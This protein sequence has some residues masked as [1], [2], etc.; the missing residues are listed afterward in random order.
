[1][2]RLLC[3]GKQL[4]QKCNDL[5]GERACP[6]VV[7]A[8]RLLRAKVEKSRGVYSIYIRKMHQLSVAA[9]LDDFD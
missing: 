5:S 8:V 9:I 4:D 7:D 2:M 6:T 1:L 3:C